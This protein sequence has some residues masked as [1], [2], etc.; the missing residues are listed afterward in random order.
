MASKATSDTL[1]LTRLQT[2]SCESGLKATRLLW[3]HATQRDA[4]SIGWLPW[5][6]FDDAATKGRIITLH[7]NDDLVGFVVWS[8]NAL[9]EI[10]CVQVWVRADARLILHGRALISELEQIAREQGCW[11]IRLWC[12]EDLAANMFWQAIGFTKQ[13]WRRGRTD[14]RRHLL[15]VR[16]VRLQACVRVAAWL[17]SQSAPA[18][19]QE[20]EQDQ[21]HQASAAEQHG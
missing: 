4:H 17:K 6:A 12:G 11:L 21:Q 15:W 10:R 9:R 18:D 19:P 8:R 1:K 13:N 20:A 3:G 5:A 7:N 14:H 2:G 16:E